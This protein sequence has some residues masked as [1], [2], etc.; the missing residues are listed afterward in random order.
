M[1]YSGVTEKEEAIKVSLLE[2]GLVFTVYVKGQVFKEEE[3]AIKV[4]LLQGGLVLVIHLK[5][6]CVSCS[7][8]QRRGGSHQ[9]GSP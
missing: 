8:V 1:A 2:G 6:V 4:D 7:G 3:E 9:G 5:G